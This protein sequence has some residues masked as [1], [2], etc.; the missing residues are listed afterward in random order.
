MQAPILHVNGDDPEAVIFATHL[1]ADYR[2]TYRKDVVIDLVCYRR[3]G[4][5]EG[6][7]P[8]KTQPLMYQKIRNHRRCA[9]STECL[10]RDWCGRARAG[11][12]N[13]RLPSRYHRGRRKCGVEFGAGAEYR[14]IRRLNPYIGHDSMRPAIHEL[15]RRT[16]SGLPLLV[17]LPNG[18][19]LHRQVSK[20]LD[21]RHRI[22]AGLLNWGMAE[23]M[24]YATLVDA[25]VPV[26]MTRQDVGVGTFSHRH[27]SL[28]NQKDGERIIPLNHVREDTPFELYDSL[29]SEEAVLAFEYGYA[30]TAPKSLVVWE[31]LGDC[32]WRA[33]GHRSVH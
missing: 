4:H 22:A 5:N 10:G 6:E 7:E 20:I 25:G 17:N 30:A 24:A 26:R 19:V 13:G 12:R 18:F 9:S 31:A 8:M 15:P 11:H 27:A 32:Q 21:D 14:T 2:M 16:F 1:A 29:L 33:G 3:R 23:I 28:F